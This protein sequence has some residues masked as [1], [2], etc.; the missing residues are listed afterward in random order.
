MKTLFV[1]D[2]IKYKEHEKKFKNRL[3]NYCEPAFYYTDYEN[4]LIKFFHSVPVIGNFFAHISYWTLSFLTAIR[5]IIF[6][7]GRYSEKV[8]INP[9]VGFFY[10]FLVS[11]FKLNENLY[12]SGFL[13]TKKS[14][15]FY[16][17]LRR[18][19]VAF[20]FRRVSQI[21][22]YSSHE[23]KI[24]AAWFPELAHKFTFVRYGR[25]YDIFEEKQYDS[26]GCYIASGGVSNRDYNRLAC[27]MKMLEEKYPDLICKVATR[28]N[29]FVMECNPMN[30]KFLYNI[31]IESFGSFL[32]KS[33]FVVLPL[34]NSPLSAGHMTLLESMYRGKNILISDIPSVRDYV[35]E[36]L[37]FFYNPDNTQ[38]L[39][40]KI[41]YLFKNKD[42]MDLKKRS[43][44]LREVYESSFCFGAFIERIAGIVSGKQLDNQASAI[45]NNATL[46]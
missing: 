40:D 37:V 25:D 42:S 17:E 30:M 13:F 27:A 1:L 20:S 46:N 31:R 28:P 26:T 45:H 36:G 29:G 32:G 12:L 39:A 11:V 33:V 34:R 4:R 38:D 44:K 6:N 8:F 16:F 22:V 10:C 23:V 14:N 19:L 24:Y 15:K 2:S 21:F 9:I 41:E 35:D 43:E 5:L 7:R 3:I 18:K